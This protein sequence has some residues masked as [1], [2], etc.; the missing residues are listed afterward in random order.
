MLVGPYSA[1]S[2]P[3]VIVLTHRRSS[4]FI[5]IEFHS[6]LVDSIVGQHPPLVAASHSSAFYSTNQLLNALSHITSFLLYSA[7]LLRSCSVLQ[8][9]LS[10]RLKDKYSLN[11]IKPDPSLVSILYDATLLPYDA[12][13]VC[14]IPEI[15]EF[16]V[17]RTPTSKW[18]YLESKTSSSIRV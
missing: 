9:V 6:S 4:A 11:R 5:H 3:Y 15:V 10:W 8:S 7:Y 1:R 14:Q 12:P 16:V 17:K 13:G 18:S 2:A